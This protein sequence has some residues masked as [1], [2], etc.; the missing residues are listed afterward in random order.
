M[1]SETTEPSLK[2]FIEVPADNHFP[3]QNL[4]Y[5]VFTLSSFKQPHI[6]VAIGDYILDL[7]V[8]N[9]EHF[10]DDFEHKEVFF[11]STLNNFMALGKPSWSKARKI[12]SNLLRVDN[13][14]LR[15]N[16][17]LR[18]NCLVEQ[19]DAT[20]VLPVSIGDYTDFY[21][22]IY[23]AT[24]VG[25]MFRGRENALQPNW[26]HLPVGYHGR[27]SSIVLDHP[28]RR[29]N[30]QI[31]R[32]NDTQPVYTSC[33]RLDFELEMGFFVG[34]G[35]N[36]GEPIDIKE[37]EKHIFGLVLVN[38][39]SARDIQK[40]EYVPLGPFNA[41]N[42]LTAISPWVVTIEAL[43]PFIIPGEKQDPTP[44]AYLKREKDFTF[45]IALETYITTDKMKEPFRLNSTNCKYLYWSMD[46]QLVHHTVTGCN[47][48]TG[49]LLA[50]GTISGPAP[51]E[52]GS[53]LELSWDETKGST[54]IELPSGEKRTF[55]EDGD[56]IIMTGW[57]QGTN[58]KIGFGKVTGKINPANTILN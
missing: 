38:D 32:K 43:E 4:P 5:G 46:Q 9:Q 10:F 50:S 12:I 15:D 2:S 23:H 18:A 58:Y 14:I 22:S 37:A 16:K 11:D 52:R 51:Y 25:I 7:F 42:F 29:P 48:R 21:S 39:W 30:G 45:N 44:V 53:M 35:N 47:L 1:F 57:A 36:I 31:F 13:P 8:L 33:K 28:V 49:D 20:M 6:G 27:A 24:N 3:I 56:S 55:L 54:P 34:P 19:K 17:E 41:K 40:W 26:K